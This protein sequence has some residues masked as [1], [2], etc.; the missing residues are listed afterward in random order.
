MPASL[1]RPLKRPRLS[2]P[3]SPVDPPDSHHAAA[4]LVPRHPLDIKPLGNAYAATDDLRA[5]CGRLSLLSDEL[6]NL[7]L[8]MLDANGLVQL[9]STCK[10]LYASARAD[11]LWKSLFIE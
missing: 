1:A 8:D 5:C 3:E 4:L 6:L 9:G 10:A 2:P 7:V 11:E